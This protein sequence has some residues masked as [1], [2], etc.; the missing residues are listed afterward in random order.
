LRN[1]RD[2]SVLDKQ[3]RTDEARLSEIFYLLAGE[4]GDS[5]VAA[6]VKSRIVDKYIETTEFT[7]HPIDASVD[8]FRL[9]QV[10]PH[11]KCPD[12]MGL[13]RVCR[14]FEAALD[15]PSWMEVTV[16]AP[17]PRMKGPGGQSHVES[18]LRKFDRS[19]KPDPLVAPDTSATA[20]ATLPPTTYYREQVIHTGPD[21]KSSH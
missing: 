11:R 16:V 5:R 14:L 6:S 12:T 4:V 8:A 3:Q 18:A 10:Q 7:E 1:H 20:T 17:L 2:K 19:G 13:D 15:D 21:W 9:E